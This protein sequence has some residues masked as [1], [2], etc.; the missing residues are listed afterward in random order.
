MAQYTEITERLAE[1]ITSFIRRLEDAHTDAIERVRDRVDPY[2]PEVETPR[3]AS[4]LPL[5]APKD[6]IRANFGLVEQILRAQKSYTLGV[7]E[8]LGRAPKRAKRAKKAKTERV[9][10]A[11]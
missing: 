8:A 3:F 10:R 11:A 5:P 2:L 1:R 4:E 9:E 7:I 6:F